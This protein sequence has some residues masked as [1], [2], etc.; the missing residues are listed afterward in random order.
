MTWRITFAGVDMTSDDFTIGEL[1]EVEKVSGVPWS[2]ANPLREVKVARAFLAVALLRSGVPDREV[3]AHLE[4]VTLRK[5]KHAFSYEP[6]EDQEGE[7]EPDP[8]DRDL[9]LSSQPSSP[10]APEGDGPPA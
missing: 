7:E 1:G 8:S 4:K 10:T 9:G 3:A 2:I 6:D 5:L